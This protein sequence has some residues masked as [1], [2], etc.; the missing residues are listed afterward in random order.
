MECKSC[1]EP[2][3]EEAAFCAA[4]GA[5]ADPGSRE[6]P[7]GARRNRL[8]LAAA[9]LV[10]VL[11][12]LAMS[13]GSIR[14]R[15]Q[16]GSDGV[17]PTS[18]SASAVTSDPTSTTIGAMQR[19]LATYTDACI[20]CHGMQGSGNL[21]PRLKPNPTVAD[22]TDADLRQV[23]EQGKGDQM[24]AWRGRLT[25]EDVESVIALLRSWQ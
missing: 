24:P 22:L 8:A 13:M 5:P 15:S 1:G 4:C 18:P 23:I 10:V 11:A 17:S 19:S 2:I 16:P 6:R 7:L 21:G 3:P 12:V 9:V 25:S 20:G 14:Q